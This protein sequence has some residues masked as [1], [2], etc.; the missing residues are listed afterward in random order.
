MQLSIDWKSFLELQ[1]KKEDLLFDLFNPT[2]KATVENI[3]LDFA[4]E[5]EMQNA[6]ETLTRRFPSL[7]VAQ[8]F[9]NNKYSSFKENEFWRFKDRKDSRI[10][11]ENCLLSLA[12][13]KDLFEKITG[14]RPFCRQFFGKSRRFI[15]CLFENEV[16]AERALNLGPRIFDQNGNLMFLSKY[17][18]NPL[19]YP[20][21]ILRGMEEECTEEDLSEFLVSKNVVKWFKLKTRQETYQSNAIMC[22]FENE[23]SAKKVAGAY[24]SNPEN[25][26]EILS[27]GKMSNR[28]SNWPL[29]LSEV[30]PSYA[31][32]NS[33]NGKIDDCNSVDDIIDESKPVDD[34]VALNATSDTTIIKDL[35]ADL[36]NPV[37][38]PPTDT[39]SDMDMLAKDGHLDTTRRE[40]LLLETGRNLRSRGKIQY[41]QVN[42]RK[43]KGVEKRKAV[44]QGIS[45]SSDP[46]VGSQ[47]I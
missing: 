8:H 18:D 26:T 46:A 32:S 35:S 41:N 37:L 36:A 13:V 34:I 45:D 27:F 23:E 29:I 22:Y 47:E 21:L 6:F 44:K 5:N 7:L 2:F 43:S 16:Y 11:V 25:E 4:N 12:E 1:I 19:I 38:R 28:A 14:A 10:I 3:T 24:Y 15:E 31:E 9:T 42:S 33:V 17:Q 40:M 39:E 20:T 30:T